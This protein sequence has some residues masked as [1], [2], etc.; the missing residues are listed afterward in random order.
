MYVPEQ[1]L[2]LDEAKYFCKNGLKQ[3]L[4]NKPIRFGYK[5]WVLATVSGYVVSFD[6]YQGKGIGSHHHPECE[7]SGGRC[8]LCPGP[9]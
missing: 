6:L 8:C 5:V 1:E 2:S 4:R 7:H 9:P 3:S